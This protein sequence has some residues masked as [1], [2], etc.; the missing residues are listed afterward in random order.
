MNLEDFYTKS[1]PILNWVFFESKEEA[2]NTFNAAEFDGWDDEWIP[3]STDQLG[4]IIV[5][6][7]QDFI[8]YINHEERGI[9]SFN[10]ISKNPPEI[11]ELLN[12]L[13]EIDDYSNVSDLSKLREITKKLLE[14]R[15][16][17]QEV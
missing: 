14:L 2:I 11:Y 5:L 4:D 10:L 9:P 12:N 3:M 1:I 16:S 17:A 7:N 8:G 6:N 15:K 13:L